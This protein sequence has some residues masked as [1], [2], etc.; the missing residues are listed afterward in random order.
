MTV[1]D[2]FETEEQVCNY[3][4][5]PW[6][7]VRASVRALH[8]ASLTLGDSPH[9]DLIRID[10]CHR[11]RLAQDAI[12]ARNAD[13]RPEYIHTLDAATSYVRAAATLP[14]AN[15]D[16]P[17]EPGAPTALDVT[18]Q[19]Y[20][21]LWG[22]FSPDHYFDEAT[23]LLRTRLERT[24][25]DLARAQSERVIDVGCGGGRYSVALRRLGFAEVVG[26]DWSTEAIET[27]NARI[28]EAGISNV[29]YR[30]ANVLELPFGDA[31]FD[32]VFSNGVLHHT[33]DTQR[34]LNELRRVVRPG[35][36]AWIYLYGRPGGLDRLTHYIARLLLRR[37]SHEVCRRYCHALGIPAN[38]TFFLLDLWLTPIAEA[39]SPDEMD[40]MLKNAGFRSW[41]RVERGAD[42]DLVERLYQREPYGEIK[43]GVGENRYIAEA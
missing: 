43:Y 21:R 24:G 42:Q 36:R 1:T 4:S 22:G 10:T 19:H 41:R 14:Q 3:L 29:S 27:A 26:V 28:A 5:I 30:R 20:G 17:G 2:T 38:R 6:P 7:D 35:G 12:F 15:T 33:L 40:E 32:V 18:A 8:Q 31:E 23:A 34:G 39:Y 11:I 13:P 25:F 9:A 16:R 37:S